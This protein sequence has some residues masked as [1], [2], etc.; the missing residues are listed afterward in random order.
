MILRGTTRPCRGT[1]IR[2]AWQMDVKLLT[3]QR[4]EREDRKYLWGKKLVQQ[5]GCPQKNRVER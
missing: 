4:L 5:Q 3:R 2:W 1:L